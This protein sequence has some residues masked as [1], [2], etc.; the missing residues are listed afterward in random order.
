MGTCSRCA[1]VYLALACV[2]TAVS[3]PQ[4]PVW[5]NN[6]VAILAETRITDSGAATVPFLNPRDGWVFFTMDPGT[7]AEALLDDQPDPLIWRVHPRSGTPEAMQHLPSGLHQVR[8]SGAGGRTIS[9]RAVPELAFCYYPSNK[10]IQAYPDYDW[11]YMSRHVLPNVNVLIS[12][13]E[14]PSAER[15]EWTREG[16]R[17]LCN[18]RLPGLGREKAPSV[19]AVLD[20]WRQNATLT[21]PG[22]SGMIVDEFVG[23]SAAHYTAWY[24]AL[25]RLHAL[26]SFSGKDFYAWCTDIFMLVPGRAFCHQI[27][28]SGD[29]FAWE[30]YVR[31][32]RF[33][34]DSEK[35]LDRELRRAMTAWQEIMP[36]IEQH[37]V[38]CLGYLSAP[39]ESLNVHPEV[40]YH[41]FLDEQFR[42]I[43]TDPAFKGLYGLM[44]Y[45]AAYADEESLRFAHLL[46]RHYC[47]EGHT[48]RFSADPYELA[49]IRNP[50]FARG[51]D[52]WEFDQN[53][54]GT[55]TLGAM[56]G[57]SWLQGRYPRT[58]DGDTFCVFTLN[59]KAPNRIDQGIRALQPGRLYSVKMISAS[60]GALDER[61][62]LPIAI[63]VSGAECLPEFGFQEPFSSCYS[64]EVGRY[65]SC[66]PA[67]FNFHRV[68]FRAQSREA[69]LTITDWP[70]GTG[71]GGPT[72]LC[73]AFNFIEVQPFWEP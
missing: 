42:L 31:E 36:G 61:A 28:N 30:K 32:D 16:R 57:F 21:Q 8:F 22:Y 4:E 65:N 67:W 40:D 26:P 10:H 52:Q 39:P 44:E 64:H 20:V 18:E 15:E 2:P 50:D 46:M 45:M 47:I 68:V 53:R 29:K 66:T 33:P 14:I 63:Q 62:V 48:D 70:D 41:V 6:L 5:L 35:R 25:K 60:L 3:Q 37:V 34:I 38:L 7:P 71:P 56:E 27:V 59:D 23:A 24:G 51:F 11:P 55:L 1:L 17:W 13:G 58:S 49:H 19:T 54:R 73:I 69:R 72:G 43:A 12:H 9:V